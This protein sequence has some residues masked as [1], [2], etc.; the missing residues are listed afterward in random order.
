MS[1][2]KVIIAGGGI[3][4]PVLAI[5]LKL[6]G[7]EPVV[8]E[9]A[10]SPTGLGLSLCLQPN[11]LKVLALIPGLVE[12]IVGKEIEKM[13]FVSVLEE[14]AGVLAQSDALSQVSARFGF[15]L[16]GT[17]R[18]VFHRTLLAAA[19]RHGVRVVFG[20]QLVALEQD[21]ESVRVTFANGH[22]DSASFV[23]GCDGLH[24]NT[25]V[26]LFGKEEATFTGLTQASGL[27]SGSECALIVNFSDRRDLPYGAHMIYYP[28][29]DKQISWAITLQEPEAKET[30]RDMDEDRQR[31][32]KKGQFS[33]WGFG[34]GEL[35]KTADTLVKYGL[36]DRPE[37]QTWHKG[38]VVLLGDAAHPTSPVP[39]RAGRQSGV[40][41][42]LPLCAA[43]HAAQPDRRGAV[44]GDALRGVR[45]ARAAAHPAHVVARE[46]G[47]EQGE[48]RVVHGVERR[49]VCNDA[50]RAAWKD[51][52]NMV[53]G[54]AM[55]F[56]QPFTGKSEI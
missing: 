18:P 38:R 14:D 39:P 49:K 7:Y 53:Q 4:G 5:F 25:R 6:K 31:E 44:H 42:H 33:Q 12:S 40:R 8:Y 24:S 50:V 10:D 37:L 21:D 20:H 48:G 23:V 41:G 17:R 13:K 29:N 34:A 36:Y 45:G 56:E 26:C 55:L 32:F 3:A 35:V 2:T 27:A 19:E 15:R 22:T 28:I 11:G 30:W 43:A 46:E 47:R 1:N 51:E 16:R 54:Y 52:G 9:R